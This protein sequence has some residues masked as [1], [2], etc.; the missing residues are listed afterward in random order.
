MANP[1]APHVPGNV[2]PADPAEQQS[3]EQAAPENN[4]TPETVSPEGRIG[5]QDR[6]SANELNQFPVQPTVEDALGIE[7]I[8]G[9]TLD[10][11]SPAVVEP[12]EAE[13]AR[14]E[15]VAERAVAAREA[16][17]EAFTSRHPA[18][19]AVAKQASDGEKEQG[20]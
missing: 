11:W 8:V 7:R 15:R 9:P 20:A 17:H 18:A 3:A 10:N 19:A 6:F 1:Q 4:E 2:K 14:L 12:D 5:S 13:I 16:R